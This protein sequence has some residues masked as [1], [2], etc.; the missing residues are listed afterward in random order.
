MYLNS[1]RPSV[2]YEDTMFVRNVTRREKQ[3]EFSTLTISRVGINFR[4]ID[5]IGITEW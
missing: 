1:I 2:G 5:T 4:R 3:H